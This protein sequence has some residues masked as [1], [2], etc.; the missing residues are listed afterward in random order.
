MTSSDG[1]VNWTKPIV[2][3]RAGPQEKF[4]NVSVSR[5]RLPVVLE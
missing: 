2:V 3:L 1:L 4:F 5:D